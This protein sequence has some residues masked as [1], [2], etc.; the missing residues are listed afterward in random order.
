MRGDLLFGSSGWEMGVLFCRVAFCGFS[1]KGIIQASKIRT[2]LMRS[3][4]PPPVVGSRKNSYKVGSPATL[5]YR[6][7][8]NHVLNMKRRGGETAVTT[9]AD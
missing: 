4:N 2:K 6:S 9:F 3:G 5:L 7:A 8:A 1:G